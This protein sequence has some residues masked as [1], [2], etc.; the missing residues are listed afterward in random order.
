MLYVCEPIAAHAKKQC[1]N[2]LEWGY[3]EFMA[4]EFFLQNVDIIDKN[5]EEIIIRRTPQKI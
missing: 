1:G 4:L 2:E 5:I 3:D